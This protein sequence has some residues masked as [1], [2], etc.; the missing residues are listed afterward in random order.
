MED[1][2]S[3]QPKLENPT[4]PSLLIVDDKDELREQMKWGL[5]CYYKVFEARDRSETVAIIEKENI[6]LVTLDLGL[7]PDPDGTSEGL[8]ALDEMLSIAPLLKVI[9]ITGNHD[10][11][12]ALKA[13]E[14]GAYDFMEKPVDLEVLKVVLHRANYLGQLEKENHDLLKRQ[15]SQNFH[16]II[17]ASPT[18]EKVFDTVRRV[19]TSDVSVLVVGESGTGKEL[20]AKA[21]HN[22]S[23]RSQERFEAVNCAAIPESLL[24]AELESVAADLSGSDTFGL[25]QLD[26]ELLDFAELD[27]LLDFD[28]EE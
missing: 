6:H 21:L 17:G 23:S 16:E 24:E 11:A 12:N 27:A 4:L 15:G 8:A 2:A 3:K 7:P 10:R 20:I 13:V 28:F 5:K 19:A 9:V 14:L 18:M 25:D 26:A 22:L 1:V